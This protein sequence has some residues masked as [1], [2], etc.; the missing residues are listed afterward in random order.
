MKGTRIDVTVQPRASRDSVELVDGERL[1]IRVTAPPEGGK[2]NAAVV[3]VLS[4]RL[5]L[6]KSRI[7]VVRG[8]TARRKVI[9]VE[10]LDRQAL[11]GRLEPKARPPEEGGPG[12]SRGGWP[13]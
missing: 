6:P 7:A 13:P 8:Q 4:S 11:L 12:R 1:G 3:A 10:G 2:A 9:F 5:R